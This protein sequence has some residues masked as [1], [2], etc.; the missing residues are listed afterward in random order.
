M[1]HVAWKKERKDPPK[2]DYSHEQPYVVSS[3]SPLHILFV[4]TS[5]MIGHG[6][7]GTCT[8]FLAMDDSR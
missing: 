6:P 5:A 8:Q 3:S 1:Y 2:L 4:D 7:N